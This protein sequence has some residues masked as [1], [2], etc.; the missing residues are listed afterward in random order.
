MFKPI[1]STFKKSGAKQTE[2]DSLVPPFERWK[3]G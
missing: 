1:P 2:L 3:K